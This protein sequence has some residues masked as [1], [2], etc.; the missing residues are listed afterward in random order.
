MTDAI[1]RAYAASPDIEDHRPRPDSPG[2]C[3]VAGGRVAAGRDGGAVEQ[4]VVEQP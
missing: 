3:V 1:L 2:C 4:V